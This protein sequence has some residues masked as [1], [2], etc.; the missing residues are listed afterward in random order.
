MSSNGIASA[1]NTLTSSGASAVA[2]EKDQRASGA[3]ANSRS[4]LV[5]LDEDG[6][7][8]IVQFVK[9]RSTTTND[10]GEITETLTQHEIPGE[11]D[12]M[13]ISGDF[14]FFRYKNAFVTW[15]NWERDTDWNYDRTNYNCNWE[16]QS[17]VIYKPTG[18]VYALADLAPVQNNNNHHYAHSNINVEI[19]DGNII[20]FWDWNTGGDRKFYALSV[21]GDELKATN[22]VPN[23][24]ITVES[25]MADKFGNV[26]VKTSS[27][28]QIDQ[29]NRVVYYSHNNLFKGDDGL[30]YD[31]RQTTINM[32]WERQ[33]H[34]LRHYTENR[35]LVVAPDDIN[36][37][38]SGANYWDGGWLVNG[39]F[40]IQIH[41]NSMSVYFRGP[42]GYEY[43]R[44]FGNIGSNNH[45]NAFLISGGQLFALVED[46]DY[47]RVLTH[48]S[49]EGLVGPEL[50]YHYRNWGHYENGHWVSGTGY[51]E[52]EPFEYI[53]GHGY[54]AYEDG[55]VYNGN[56]RWINHPNG[57]YQAD[58]AGVRVDYVWIPGYW[59]MECGTPAVW[60]GIDG[61]WHNG[62]FVPQFSVDDDEWWFYQFNHG[63]NNQLN[64]SKVTPITNATSAYIQNGQ[65][66][67]V[68]DTLT[69]RDVA[70]IGIVNGEFVV[71]H[72]SSSTFTG[73]VITLRPL[74]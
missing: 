16:F 19:M 71:N 42:N 21:E 69:S 46:E 29:A 23:T 61:Y 5:T 32:G 64:F 27:L 57:G 62:D 43:W 2:D 47:N 3:G 24:N 12:K 49:L 33:V 74:N 45:N 56:I 70:T 6:N 13:F 67:V 58:E 66:F 36:V 4:F 1:Q 15:W 53:E 73:T 28:N 9:R 10:D 65:L 40:L 18:K 20:A 50:E 30:V 8:S 22:L 48:F 60:I 7:P 51:W 38:L 25:V 72:A 39:D 37:Y 11:I 17:F 34:N 31:L 44:W 14:V 55:T 63:H 26:Y 68:V 59:A 35:T 52:E 41:W 54:Y